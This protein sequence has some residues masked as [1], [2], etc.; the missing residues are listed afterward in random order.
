MTKTVSLLVTR[1]SRNRGE[2]APCNTLK[3]TSSSE[4][5]IRADRG[6]TFAKVA[7]HHRNGPSRNPLRPT[8]GHYAR[9]LFSRIRGLVTREEKSPRYL[10]SFSRILSRVLLSLVYIYGAILAYSETRL[11]LRIAK[12]KTKSKRTAG[13]LT[14]AALETACM[15]KRDKSICHHQKN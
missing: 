4:S 13:K 9:L 2:S 7:I 14:T 8:S 10:N 1:S 15:S 5:L 11:S 12:T 6:R 3:S